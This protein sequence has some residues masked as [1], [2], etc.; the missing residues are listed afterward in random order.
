MGVNG[1]PTLFYGFLEIIPSRP[2]CQ[3]GTA[4]QTFGFSY[5]RKTVPE[6][7]HACDYQ[8]GE[9]S[10]ATLDQTFF[11]VKQY[12]WD[13][14]RSRH[15]WVDATSSGDGN[16]VWSNGVAVESSVWADGEPDDDDVV[17]RLDDKQNDIRLEGKNNPDNDEYYVC[18]G[19][20]ETSG[21]HIEWTTLGGYDNDDDNDDDEEDDGR[22]D[23]D[24]DND[25]DDDDDDD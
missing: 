25:F 17:A 10:L 4:S 9:V 7:R 6:A 23:D 24:N 21:A 2:L 20:P 15:Y 13:N 5:E 3:S 18:E 8:P 19:V 12:V 22:D 1:D 14:Y 11:E 16:Y